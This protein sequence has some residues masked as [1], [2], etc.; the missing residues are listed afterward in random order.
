MG[1]GEWGVEVQ[2]YNLMNIENKK[3]KDEVYLKAE[4]GHLMTMAFLSA[5]KSNFDH[6]KAFEV[7][8]KGFANYMISYYNIALSSTTPG[9]QERFDKF[10]EL[11]RAGANKSNYIDIVESS[12]EVLKIRFSRCPFFEVMVV[13]GLLEFSSAYCLSDYAFTEECLPGVKF[14]RNHE[15]VK[16]DNYCDHTWMYI[17]SNNK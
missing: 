9:T 10:R 12:P 11:H 8:A 14:S 4:Q 5:L 3:D 6:E 16:G 2:A 15:I 7:A 17:A 1:K 13:Y